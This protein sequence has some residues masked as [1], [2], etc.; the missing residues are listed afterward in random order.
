MPWLPFARKDLATGGGQR[1]SRSRSLSRARSAGVRD[2]MRRSR[3]SASFS[4]A[5]DSAPPVGNGGGFPQGSLGLCAPCRCIEVS[6]AL[7]H[8]DAAWRN[9]RQSGRIRGSPVSASS[10]PASPF[11]SCV[12]LQGRMEGSFLGGVSTGETRSK[13]WPKTGRHAAAGWLVCVRLAC[14]GGTSS[15]R[16]RPDRRGPWRRWRVRE[17]QRDSAS[18]QKM[19]RLGSH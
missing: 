8:R 11:V 3:R 1:R 6:A 9:R 18:T 4:T 19:A 10:H 14:D 17:Q 5:P 13:T 2:A 12:Q 15:S 16:R 7:T